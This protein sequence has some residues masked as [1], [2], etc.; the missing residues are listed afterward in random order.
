MDNLAILIPCYNEET[1]IYKVVQDCLTATK[2]MEN[3]KVYV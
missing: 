1:T 3:V 2:N